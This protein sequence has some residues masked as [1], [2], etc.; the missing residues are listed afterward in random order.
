MHAAQAVRV[1]LQ[2]VADDGVMEGTARI[3]TFAVALL[4]DSLLFALLVGA[5]PADIVPVN[6]DHPFNFVV[7]YW[8][9]KKR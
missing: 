1:R 2:V 8:I 6:V 5:D 7:C 9:L 3:K 4:L